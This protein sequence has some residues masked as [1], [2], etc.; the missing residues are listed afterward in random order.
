M[1]L[2]AG[3]AVLQS[4]LALPISACLVKM[5][6]Q[7]IWSGWQALYLSACAQL[8]ILRQTG[9]DVCA[10]WSQCRVQQASKTLSGL[11]LCPTCLCPLS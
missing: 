9:S 4:V 8:G 10:W 11:I 2:W 7:V 3:W 1:I 6:W 5:T